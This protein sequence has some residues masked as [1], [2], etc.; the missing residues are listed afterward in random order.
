M[1][2]DY[3]LNLDGVPC[4]DLGEGV[5]HRVCR[6]CGGSWCGEPEGAC[7]WCVDADERQRLEQRRRLLFPDFLH[8]ESPRY[9]DLGEL[10]RAAWDR[11][12]G[13][14]RGEGSRRAWGERLARAVESGLITDT[15]ARAAIERSRR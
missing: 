8:E 12:R 4:P 13:I 10:D 15:E 5:V 6:D 14:E 3:G 2:S 11:T 9:D 1:S 7:P